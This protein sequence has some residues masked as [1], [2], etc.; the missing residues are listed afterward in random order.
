MQPAGRRLPPDGALSA[1]E[2]GSGAEV[3]LQH[4]LLSLLPVLAAD[5]ALA[6][7]LR[8]QRAQLRVSLPPLPNKTAGRTAAPV[9][10]TLHR[11]NEAEALLLLD[12][13]RMRRLLLALLALRPAAH[14][15]PCT[16][17]SS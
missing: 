10:L 16:E 8:S 2:D 3:L 1:T 5:H 14:T 17:T 11:G 15:P 13:V 9:A 12:R 7:E 6:Q 4:L